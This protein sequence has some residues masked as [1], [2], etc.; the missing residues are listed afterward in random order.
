MMRLKAAIIGLGQVG[1]LFDE[2]PERRGSVE[3]WTHFTAYE[4][5][6]DIYELVCAVDPDASR[7]E[8]ALKRKPGLRVYETVEAMLDRENLDVVSICTP[9][10][11]HLD[12]LRILKNDVKGIFLEKPLC[13]LDALK[14]AIDITTELRA[15]GV[16]VRVNFYKQEEPLFIKML[17]HAAGQRIVHVSVHY[18]GPFTAVGSHA[19]NSLLVV[20]PEIRVVAASRYIHPEGNG[21]SA[22]MSGADGIYADLVYCGNRHNLIFEMEIITDRGKYILERNLSVLRSYRF[23]KSKRYQGYRELV[24]LEVIRETGNFR[25]FIFPLEEIAKEIA[26][27]RPDYRNLENALKTQLIME[28]IQ[29]LAMRKEF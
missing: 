28:E 3:T 4:R 29:H 16:C 14:E 15:R 5:L 20:L 27:G 19:L 17:Q 11:F 26:S 22:F 10:E 13:G 18:S 8:K 1:I 2:E 12:C 6:S 7:R 24:P 25:R 9:D 23:E 21:Y